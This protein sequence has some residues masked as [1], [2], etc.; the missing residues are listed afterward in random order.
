M[1]TSRQTVMQKH[2]TKLC[3]ALAAA[4][5]LTSCTPAEPPSPWEQARASNQNRSVSQ[6]FPDHPVVLDD[7]YGFASSEL[8]FSSSEIAVVVDETVTAGLRGASVAMVTHAPLL[9][10]TSENHSDVVAEI[11]RLGAHTV[12]TVG[13]VG[14]APTSGYISIVRDPGGQKALEKMTALR[15]EEQVVQRPEDAVESV[16]AAPQEHPV[17]LRAS[18]ADPL[19][20]ANARARPVPAQGPRDASM[21]PKVVATPRSDFAAVVNARSYGADVEVVENPDPRQSEE[22][23]T[24]MIGLSSEPLIAFGSEFGTSAKLAEA[25]QGAE[26]EL[27]P[28]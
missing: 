2:L 3:A 24:E 27:P 1:T 5:V 4:A 14:L 19:V 10:Y 20:Q 15:Y 8:F 28:R 9:V 18:W 17:W 6:A 22:A 23:L 21:A 25:I 11:R 7:P 26:Q 16:A 13:A 12:L